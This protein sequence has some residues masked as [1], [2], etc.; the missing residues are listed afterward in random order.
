MQASKESNK[1]DNENNEKV[2]DIHDITL[3]IIKKHSRI[4][5]PLLLVLEDVQE[6]LGFVPK[7]AMLLISSELN[8]PLSR[9]Y[10]V[11]TFYNE[12]KT[13]KRGKHIIRVCLGTACA[14]KKNHNNLDFLRSELNVEPGFTTSD[15]LIT[16]ETVNCFG[17]CSMAPIVEV[18][19]KLIGNITRE[20]LKE[21]LGSLK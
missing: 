21:I 13:R 1:R 2:H 5:D 11:V 7:E 17:A 4:R 15:G 16:L 18:D 19:G 14:V 6:T 12:L 8:I 9:V 20:K 3:R 10:S